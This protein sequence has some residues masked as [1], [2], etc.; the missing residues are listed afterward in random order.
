[1]SRIE[2][3]LFKQFEFLRL[4]ERLSHCP[5]VTKGLKLLLWNY[6]LCSILSVY[7]DLFVAF[8]KCHYKLILK[9]VLD[10]ST[11]LALLA[12]SASA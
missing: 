2:L 9:F 10:Y 5:L 11:N 7:L 12:H 6:D 3:H 8:V 4:V 1:M